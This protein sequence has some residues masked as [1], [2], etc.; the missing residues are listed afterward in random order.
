MTIEI[1]RDE[2]AYVAKLVHTNLMAL[3]VQS[4]SANPC[5]RTVAQLLSATYQLID[6]LVPIKIRHKP[7]NERISAEDAWKTL[8]PHV[9][10]LSKFMVA[11]CTKQK[12]TAFL[13]R[14]CRNR[15]LAIGILTN[16]ILQCKEIKRALNGDVKPYS[17]AV[18]GPVLT[19]RPNKDRIE[20]L[21]MKIVSKLEMNRLPEDLQTIM[22]NLTAISDQTASGVLNLTEIAELIGPIID[23]IQVRVEIPPLRGRPGTN[24]SREWIKMATRQCLE[25]VS[26]LYRQLLRLPEDQLQQEE[27]QKQATRVLV[28]LFVTYRDIYLAPNVQNALNETA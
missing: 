6:H 15:L 9:P 7:S 14:I 10:H 23:L 5:M 27:F 22:V 8:E 20:E 2:L 21:M 3:K 16:S 24:T 13:A 26:N 4:E 28:R 25:S 17:I 11:Y 12:D 18:D 1:D 19:N